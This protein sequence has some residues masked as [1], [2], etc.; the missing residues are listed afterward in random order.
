MFA[1]RPAHDYYAGQGHRHR[2]RR[3]PYVI[4]GDR[5]R[6]RGND[7]VW[8]GGTGHH[9]PLRFPRPVRLALPRHRRR[10]QRRADRRRVAPADSRATASTWSGERIDLALDAA[11]AELRHGRATGAPQHASSTWS[12]TPSGSTS[13]NRKLEQTLAWG[14][15][16]AAVRALDR[17]RHPG[18]LARVRHAGPAAQGDPRVRRCLGRRLSRLRHRGPRLDRRARRW[19]PASSPRDSAGKPRARVLSRSTPGRPRQSYQLQQNAR[20]ATALHHLCPGRRRSP[21]P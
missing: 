11:R 6:F 15:A 3:E 7:R 20:Q 4:V 1:D 16:V 18:R 9:R 12:P 8:A 13:T 19:W 17:L 5:V 21:S 10:E 2:S 14:K